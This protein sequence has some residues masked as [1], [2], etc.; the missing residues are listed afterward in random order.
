MS[1]QPKIPA[2]PA[3]R[4]TSKLF[5]AAAIVVVGQLLAPTALRAQTTNRPP[6]ILF[7]IM[8]DVGIDQLKSFNPL[9]PQAT[10]ILNTL[11]QQGVSFNNCWM[12][13]E[14]SPSRA[15]YFTGR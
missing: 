13:P 2:I 10:P 15:C 5:A 7:I 12:M 4:V 6:N 1:H 11:A 9:A 8:D 14:C 3:H